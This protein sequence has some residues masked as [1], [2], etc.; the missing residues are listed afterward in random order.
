M[1]PAQSDFKQA[2]QIQK[3]HLHWNLEDLDPHPRQTGDWQYDLLTILG[4][5]FYICKTGWL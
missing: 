5:S 2:Q 3:E 4:L 1:G